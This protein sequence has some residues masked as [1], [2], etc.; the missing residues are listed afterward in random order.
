ME[1]SDKVEKIHKAFKRLPD[2]YDPEQGDPAD[3]ALSVVLTGSAQKAFTLRMKGDECNFEE[4]DADD[5]KVKVIARPEIFYSVVR[6]EM[7]PMNAVMTGRMNVKGSM[8]FLQDFEKYFTDMPEGF[9][10]KGEDFWSKV[11]FLMDE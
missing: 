2:V 7:S 3:G 8:S 4:G 10:S 11:R 1:T 9:D 6:G 5:A